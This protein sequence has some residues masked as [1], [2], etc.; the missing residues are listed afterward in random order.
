MTQKPQKFIHMIDTFREN[1]KN[2]NRGIQTMIVDAVNEL[3]GLVATSN[4][5]P[6]DVSILEKADMSDRGGKVFEAAILTAM[7]PIR[8]ILTLAETVI[9][10]HKL[11]ET[12]GRFFEAMGA[13]PNA[14]KVVATGEMPKEYGNQTNAEIKEWV[15]ELKELYSSMEGLGDEAAKKDLITG[16]VEAHGNEIK[17]SNEA[18][19]EEAQRVLAQDS[20]D[21][22]EVADADVPGTKV[23]QTTA[24]AT[25]D[26]PQ[27]TEEEAQL[28]IKRAMAAG[29][30]PYPKERNKTTKNSNLQQGQ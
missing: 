13:I 9:A 6:I 22:P 1:E 7:A 11:K 19:L 8:V 26:V 17:E 14:L 20:P 3:E 18:K 23:V 16:L 4:G 29:Q 30:I 25:T 10:P 21:A 5:A 12:Y 27:M 15:K 24:R 2:D 28:V